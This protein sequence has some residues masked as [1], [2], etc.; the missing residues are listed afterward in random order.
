M[1]VQLETLEFEIQ[2]SAEQASKG[3]DALSESLG[4]L[5]IASRN[6]SALSAT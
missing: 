3:I 1:S 2:S 6:L 4:R 5:R